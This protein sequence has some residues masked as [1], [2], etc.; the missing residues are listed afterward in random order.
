MKTLLSFFTFIIITAELTAQNCPYLRIEFAELAAVGHGGVWTGRYDF[1]DTEKDGFPPH[2]VLH[3]GN[4]FIKNVE[5]PY[6]LIT[7]YGFDKSKYTNFAKMHSWKGY[8]IA[9]KESYNRIW[10]I[11]YNEKQSNA[12]HHE[13]C[14]K[15][16]NAAITRCD[17]NPNF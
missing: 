3:L 14:T 2:A 8:E 6:G 15:M 10:V 9:I 5:N 17:R 7:V 4:L 13:W 11:I 12:E 1:I 16:F